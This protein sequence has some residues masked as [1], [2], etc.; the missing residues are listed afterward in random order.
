MGDHCMGLGEIVPLAWRDD[1]TNAMALPGRPCNSDVLECQ[2]SRNNGYM[3]N[4]FDSPSY[5]NSLAFR[6]DSSPPVR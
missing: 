2:H 6:C 4:M 1:A 3:E 5:L